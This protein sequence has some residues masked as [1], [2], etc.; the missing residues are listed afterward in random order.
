MQFNVKFHNLMDR[1][2]IFSTILNKRNITFLRIQRSLIIYQGF[3]LP[4]EKFDL[5]KRSET[6]FEQNKNMRVT[7]QS[8]KFFYQRSKRA[9]KSLV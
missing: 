6:R 1:V 2:L 8:I 3:K 4:P 7:I 9:C 5:I